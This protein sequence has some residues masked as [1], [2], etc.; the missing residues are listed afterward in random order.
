M[1]K[2]LMYL[3][4]F[5][6]YTF[7]LLWF[8]KGGFKR[9]KDNK[10]FFVAGNSLGLKA[11]IF[12]FTATWFSAASMQGLTGTLYA[13]GYSVILYSVVGWFLGAVF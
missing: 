12:T 2:S 4:Y 3:I 10:D 8:G 13:Y 11:S 6:F 9:T 5:A 1:N 7:V